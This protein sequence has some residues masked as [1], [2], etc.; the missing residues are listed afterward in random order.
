M[1]PNRREDFGVFFFWRTSKRLQGLPSFWTKEQMR[2]LLDAQSLA[3]SGWT[4][5]EGVETYRFDTPPEV[6]KFTGTTRTLPGASFTRR[7]DIVERTPAAGGGATTGRR[8]VGGRA[9]AG[10]QTLTGVFTMSGDTTDW[11]PAA[12][13]GGAA[14][15]A[16][17]VGGSAAVDAGAA[18]GGATAFADEAGVEVGMIAQ[19]QQRNPGKLITIELDVFEYGACIKRYV[20]AM[21]ALV[22]A[23]TA[24]KTPEGLLEA[25]KLDD[26]GP[27]EMFAHFARHKTRA[28]LKVKL[29]AT[30]KIIYA[31]IARP[32]RGRSG[33]QGG[34]ATGGGGAAVP[35]DPGAQEGAATEGGGGAGGADTSAQG[36]PATGGTAA[37]ACCLCWGN[38]EHQPP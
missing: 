20:D 13:G 8:A 33:A 1:L 37:I 31:Q 18:S 17:A 26:H 15:A 23:S 28:S 16:G 19:M 27:D 24:K 4:T 3:G 6:Y 22:N 10:G 35:T 25:L 14:L 30:E 9:A 36:G 5:T 11:T 38:T 34:P 21:R 2:L 12:G 32:L 7:G 29:A